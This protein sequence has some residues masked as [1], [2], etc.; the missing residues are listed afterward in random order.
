[1]F[2]NTGLLCSGANESHRA[3]R[4]ADNG[5]NYL[6][7]TSLAPRMFGD[8]A[9]ADLFHQAASAAHTHHAKVLQTH[10]E[11]LSAVGSKAHQ[12][13]AE[14]TEVHEGNAAKLLAVQRNYET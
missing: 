12:A 5:V 6:S 14:F 2:V 11:T 8:F 4:Y 9:A 3:S 13:A 10:G 7:R 1:M